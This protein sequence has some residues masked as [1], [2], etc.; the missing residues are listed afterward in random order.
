MA[1]VRTYLVDLNAQLGGDDVADFGQDLGLVLRGGRAARSGW[2]PGAIEATAAG[3]RCGVGPTHLDGEHNDVAA[4]GS[5]DAGGG[6]HAGGLRS[7]HK[8]VQRYRPTAS[9]G[10][11]PRARQAA[12]AAAALVTAAVHILTGL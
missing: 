12:A 5:G 4:A 1:L 7:R 3:A 10:E 6:S 8:R 9:R 2:R 11:K